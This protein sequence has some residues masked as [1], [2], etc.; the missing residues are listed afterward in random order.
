MRIED[1]IIDDTEN[2]ISLHKDCNY[3]GYKGDSACSKPDKTRVSF[4]GVKRKIIEKLNKMQ[5]EGS[6][7]LKKLITNPDTSSILI[8]ARHLF[9]KEE[10]EDLAKYLKKEKILL[11]YKIDIY[12]KLAA[13]TEDMYHE[14]LVKASIFNFTNNCLFTFKIELVN[15]DDKF[16]IN[17]IIHNHS[18]FN[19]MLI[20]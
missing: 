18:A 13:N 14:V 2:I 20:I 6:A 4:T 3:E 9:S 12:A 8:T 1:I 5:R 15:P 19:H 16:I 7:V 17:S 11:R 10:I